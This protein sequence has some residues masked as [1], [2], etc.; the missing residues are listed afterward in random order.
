MTLYANTLCRT[1]M[2]RH[3]PVHPVLLLMYTSAHQ[4]S[5]CVRFAVTEYELVSVLLVRQPARRVHPRF[6][7]LWLWGLVVLWQI[8]EARELLE[9]KNLEGA[10]DHEENARFEVLDN[11]LKH[12]S[13][14]S[15][16]DITKS[17]KLYPAC[18]CDTFRLDHREDTHRVPEQQFVEGYTIQENLKWTKSAENRFIHPGVEGIR[19]GI[20]LHANKS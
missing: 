11:R 14:K 16:C 12:L 13:S 17:R 6:E 18:A 20:T 3:D 1:T 4:L 19:R 8:P 5:A 7:R 2:S 15:L 10:G 9:G